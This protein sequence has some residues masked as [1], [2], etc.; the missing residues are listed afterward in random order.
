MDIAERDLIAQSPGKDK[1]APVLP[2]HE[3]LRT[4]RSVGECFKLMHF[5]QKACE[6]QMKVLTCDAEY[7]EILK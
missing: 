5:L 1:V 4:G 3:L 2:H 6:I 7:V